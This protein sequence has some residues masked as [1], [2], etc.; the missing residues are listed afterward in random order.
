MNEKTSARNYFFAQTDSTMQAFLP[1]VILS[2]LLHIILFASLFYTPGSFFKKKITPSAINVNLVSLPEYFPEPEIPKT[3][4]SMKKE[5]QLQKPEPKR[6][7]KQSSRKF[8]INPVQRRLK[9]HRNRLNPKLLLRKKP[10][11]AGRL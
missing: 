2:F 10:L 9:L 8:L 11:K 1:S 7:R 6:N 5:T 4:K 3:K